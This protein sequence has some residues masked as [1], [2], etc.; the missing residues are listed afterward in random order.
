MT[1]A[2]SPKIT[3]DEI[4]QALAWDRAER[5]YQMQLRS[6]YLRADADAFRKVR[7]D[8]PTALPPEELRYIP[9]FGQPTA[10]RPP[11]T[12]QQQAPAPAAQP[13]QPSRFDQAKAHAKILISAAK[14]GTANVGGADVLR[15]VKRTFP[16]I[17]DDEA[18]R[19]IRAAEQE[20]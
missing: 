4:N 14:A 2:T 13:R 17:S 6:S 9:E 18:Q 19:A 8:D 1:A 15:D 7:L 11:A 12:T 10:S 5:Y 16:G 3:A 20:A